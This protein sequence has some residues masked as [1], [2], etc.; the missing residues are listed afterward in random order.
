MLAH[1]LFRDWEVDADGNRP[2][3]VLKIAGW[4]LVAGG[5]W[6][7]PMEDADCSA[8]GPPFPCSLSIS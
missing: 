5:S 2:T 4:V 7:Q 6:A 1:R 3:Y 8:G